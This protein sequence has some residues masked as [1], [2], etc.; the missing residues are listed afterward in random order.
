MTRAGVY[1]KQIGGYQAFIPAPLPPEPPV[2]FA[3]ELIAALSQADQAIARLDGIT[4]TLPN[5]D[6]FVGM[7]VRREAVLSSQIE[8]TQS[9]LDDVLEFEADEKG[10]ETPKDVADV[11]NY[12]KAMNHGLERLKELPVCL[13]LLREIHSVLMPGLRGG[14]RRP[15]EFRTGPVWIGASQKVPIERAT[16]IPPPVDEMHKAL[17]HFERFLNE[18]RKLPVLVHS[19]LAHAQFETIHPFYDG[20]GRI[21]RLLITFLL[22][23]REV[24]RHPLLYLSVFLKRNRIEYYDRLMAIRNEGDWEGWLRFFLRGV[25]ETAT[26]ATETAVRILELRE[27]HRKAIREHGLGA[28]ALRLLDYLYQHPLT[29]VRAVARELDVAFATANK[30]VGRLEGLGLLTETTRGRRNRRYRYTAYV[31]LFEEGEPSGISGNQA[32]VG[33]Q[34]LPPV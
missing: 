21:G 14:N 25:A 11:V 23:E 28:D 4:W 12:V 33:P 13:R 8:G 16:F 24:L 32:Q 15:G 22:M 26:E 3:P 9:S 31:A 19:G 27:K 18:E 17:E 10:G 34:S 2:Q 30:L 6:L 20:N 7:Y 29:N 1:V 5:P